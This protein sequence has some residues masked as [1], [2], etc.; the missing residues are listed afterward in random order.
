MIEVV[1]MSSK[2]QL[3]IPREIREEMGL[4][5]Q[6]K[7]V[8]VHDNSSILLKRISKEEA[9]KAMLGLMDKISDQF[10]KAGIKRGQVASEIKKARGS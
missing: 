5:M 1:T 4:Q 6:D 9:N 3:V 8:V 7:F 2:G 10:R